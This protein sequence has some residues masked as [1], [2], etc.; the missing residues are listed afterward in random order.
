S[1]LP[2]TI[3]RLQAPLG[4]WY[5]LGN[6]DRRLI[7]DELRQMLSDLGWRNLGGRTEV[8]EQD[9]GK[10]VLGG[11][12]VPWMGT[13]PDFTAAPDDAFRLLL[14]H[15]P[16]NFRWAQQNDVGLMLSGHN[17]GG[18]VIVPGIGPI[19]SPS[20]YGVKYASGLF[21]EN[22]TLLSVCRG[23]SGDHP[24]RLNCRPELSGLILRS[25]RARPADS[26]LHGTRAAT[27]GCQAGAATAGS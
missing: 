11:S 23:L 14:S 4:C 25:P 6:H 27:G 24:L 13:H 26:T 9:G 20:Y 12:E 15:T 17:H 3:G 5:I 10:M 2:D 1:W 22:G 7:S 16:D 19:Y 8:I 21:E 18:Q